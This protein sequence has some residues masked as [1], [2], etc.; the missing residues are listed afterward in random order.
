MPSSLRKLDNR[1]AWV[2]V[3][4][5]VCDATTRRR[6]LLV[7]GPTGCGKTVGICV[8][9]RH[10][11]IE[12]IVIDG[13][14]AD[15]THQLLDW[16]RLA[17]KRLSGGIAV[18]LDDFESFTPM[19]R[20][21]VVRL[22]M[23]DRSE[24]CTVPIIVTCTQ[25]R[26]PDMAALDSLP[27]VRLRAPHERTVQEWFMSKG[28]SAGLMRDV[29]G[30]DIRRVRIA[31][32]WRRAMRQ[33]LRTQSSGIPVNAFE[34]ARDLL[35]RRTTASHWAQH[36]ESRDVT[37]LHEHL[38]IHAISDQSTAKDDAIHA[39]ADACEIFSFADATI[40]AR[41]E[42]RTLH[43]HYLLYAVGLTV[44]LTSRA[45]D[46]G[47]LPPPSRP[48]TTKD[49][50]AGTPSW[51]STDVPSLLSGRT[52]SEDGTTRRPASTRGR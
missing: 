24:L 15:D 11:S 22:I 35:L 17:M 5:H 9:L 19:A 20:A 36:A 12:A 39:I 43:A 31:L 50:P 49:R 41:F 51:W 14:Q 30:G 34:S 40:P 46:V 37:L 26:H 42:T 4:R 48:K 13:V 29:S 23:K 16:I 28:Y 18:V 10:L 33:S 38:P 45:R 8:L 44:R 32:D 21:A 2:Q 47:A 52:E 1:P 25:R 7:W 6:P 3:A 27:H